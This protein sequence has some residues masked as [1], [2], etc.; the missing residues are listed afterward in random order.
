HPAKR[1]LGDSQHVQ[2]V[3]DLEAGIAVDEMHHPVMGAAE[4]ESLELVVGIAD[5]VAVGEE[6]QFNDVP[7]QFAGPQ[8]RGSTGGALRIGARR[9]LR[10]IYVSHVDI[11]WV[12][13]YKTTS[14]DETL[15]RF[16]LGDVSG[17]RKRQR[18]RQRPQ[19]DYRAIVE[20]YF[21]KHTGLRHP[22]KG[23]RH[24]HGSAGNRPQGWWVVKS[25]PVTSRSRAGW[26]QDRAD[27]DSGKQ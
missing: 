6:Q 13:C 24:G 11:S 9:A 27:S 17:S 1:L 2:Q 8:G 7:A 25:R 20:R 12:Q 16:E 10:K 21:G 14:H 23:C 3:G 4:P 5:E 22:A 19:M 18:W 26:R 15:S